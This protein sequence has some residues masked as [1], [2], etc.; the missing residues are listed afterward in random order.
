MKKLILLSTFILLSVVR[1]NAQDVHEFKVKGF[2]IVTFIDNGVD[3]NKVICPWKSPHWG[4]SKNNMSRPYDDWS[5]AFELSG[6]NTGTYEYN[7]S[8]NTYY[9]DGDYTIDIEIDTWVS[10]IG[11]MSAMLVIKPVGSNQ[12]VGRVLFRKHYRLFKRPNRKD[13]DAQIR[14]LRAVK[15]A[16]VGVAY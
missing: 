5:Y 8:D 10:A 13:K 11:K 2:G 3:F 16:S 9:F 7:K 12:V 4:S 1:L 6:W 14:L 15:Q